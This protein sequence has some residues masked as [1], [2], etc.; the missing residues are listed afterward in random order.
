MFQAAVY[1]SGYN[2]FAP[3]WSVWN[4]TYYDT[5]IHDNHNL[6]LASSITLLTSHLSIKYHI[7]CYCGI[8][9]VGQHRRN[10]CELLEN[11]PVI[12]SLWQE[13]TCYIVWQLC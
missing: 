10:S 11:Y 4:Q 2:R 5:S 13:W 12:S 9:S 1:R 7:I 6:H 3:Y 8:H